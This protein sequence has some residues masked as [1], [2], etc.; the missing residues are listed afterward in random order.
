MFNAVTNKITLNWTY[1]D[2]FKAVIQKNHSKVDMF[3]AVTNK[4]TLKRTCVDMFNAVTY[5]IT[6]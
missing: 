2:M 5:R 4:I 3:N 1:M 6:I